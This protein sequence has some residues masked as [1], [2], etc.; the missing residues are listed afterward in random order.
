MGLTGRN[1]TIAIWNWTGYELTFDSDTVIH[2]KY[3]DEM[4]PPQ[5]IGANG[6]GCFAVGNNTGNPVGP[7]GILVYKIALQDFKLYLTWDH[8]FSGAT[9]AY[10]CFSE[11]PDGMIDAVLY[12]NEPT[13]NDQ[14]ITWTVRLRS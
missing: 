13:G 3:H 14:E 5:T 1:S 2:G 12:P 11:E 9:S 6:M 7:K 4:K 10:Y 8:P